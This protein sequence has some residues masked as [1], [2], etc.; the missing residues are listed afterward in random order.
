[1]CSNALELHVGKPRHLNY[2]PVL[3]EDYKLLELDEATLTEVLE[4]G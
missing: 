1:M 2:A 3:R 4:L